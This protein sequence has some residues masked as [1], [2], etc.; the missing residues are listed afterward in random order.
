MVHSMK[1]LHELVFE[2]SQASILSKGDN[3][4]FMLERVEKRLQIEKHKF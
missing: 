1:W 4:N 3:W 2:Q